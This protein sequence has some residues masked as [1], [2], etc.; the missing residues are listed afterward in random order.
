MPQYDYHCSV[1]KKTSVI[2]IAIDMDLDSKDRMKKLDDDLKLPRNCG[3]CNKAMER[4]F[5]PESVPN[6]QFVSGAAPPG[7]AS[8]NAR[9]AQKLI[10]LAD[11]NFESVGE[12]QEGW[13]RAKDLEKER[14]LTPGTIT[15]GVKAPKPGD[16]K[17]K[18][19][20]SKRDNIKKKEARQQRRKMGIS[21]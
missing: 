18:E 1:C 17:A 13:G 3:I 7:K 8:K 6:F 10:E 14:G 20:I 19:A 9:E 4:V 12:M 11:T 16:K 21:H 2:R 15:G 5:D